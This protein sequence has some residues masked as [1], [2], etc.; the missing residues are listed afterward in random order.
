MAQYQHL[1][2]SL[3][4][5]L[6]SQFWI[7]GCLALIAALFAVALRRQ[8]RLFKAP[9]FIMLSVG[10]AFDMLTP[11]ARSVESWM[12]YWQAAALTLVLFGVFGSQSKR[13]R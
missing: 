13:R 7:E 12:H 4:A 2:G 1:L 5:Q 6:R 3:L 8:K 9:G 10:L 11:Y